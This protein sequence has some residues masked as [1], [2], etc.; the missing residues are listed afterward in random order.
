MT[1][2]QKMKFLYLLGEYHKKY[3]ALLNNF[4]YENTSVTLYKGMIEV[5]CKAKAVDDQLKAIESSAGDA[6]STL[7][8]K[9]MEV[10]DDVLGYLETHNVLKRIKA[11]KMMNK[12]DSAINDLILD[13]IRPSKIERPIKLRF[14]SP[15]CLRVLENN[16]LLS[17]IA[18]D[19]LLWAGIV[20]LGQ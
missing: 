12:M 15:K 5:M 4:G 2:M 9:V 20:K 8:T 13:K 17:D 10:A 19:V 7:L 14:T 16:E 6:E 18:I 3:S 11:E 1:E